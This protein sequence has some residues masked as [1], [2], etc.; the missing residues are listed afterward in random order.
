MQARETNPANGCQLASN[1]AV[2]YYLGNAKDQA[3]AELERI[4]PLTAT[5]FS[6]ICRQALFFLGELYA[7]LGRTADAQGLYQAYLQ[8][9][10]TFTDDTSL[11]YRQLAQQRLTP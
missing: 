5:D 9:T 7:E 3:Q 1:L 10:A 8:A 6:P 4:R 11:R 2:L